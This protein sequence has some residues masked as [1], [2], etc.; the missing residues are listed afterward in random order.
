MTWEPD[1]A[2]A[3]SAT[4]ASASSSPRQRHPRHGGQCTSRRT[5]P[6]RRPCCA[7]GCCP[8]ATGS[9]HGARDRRWHGGDAD[10]RDL[11]KGLLHLGQHAGRVVGAVLLGPLG[12]ASTVHRSLWERPGWTIRAPPRLHA[13]GWYGLHSTV[14]PGWTGRP[15]WPWDRTASAPS[16]VPSPRPPCP[17]PATGPGA[18]SAAAGAPGARAGR[19]SL[20]RIPCGS[21]WSARSSPHAGSSRASRAG[22]RAW[23][24]AGPDAG[25]RRPTAARPRAMGRACMSGVATQWASVGAGA[26]LDWRPCASSTRSVLTLQ[27]GTGRARSA[28]ASSKRLSRTVKYCA[29]MSKAPC[30]ALTERM[31]PPTWGSRS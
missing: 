24:R 21:A 28:G 7:N 30:A 6:G 20:H 9:G 18:W 3:Q 2:S 12:L 8:A 14:G 13:H 15:R 4:M 1:T 19:V 17:A 29:P 10:A 31:R 16:R 5:G 11:A 26:A 27:G 22:V 23:S 25:G